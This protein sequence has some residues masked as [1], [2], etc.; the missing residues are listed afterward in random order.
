MESAEHGLPTA[1]EVPRFD[2]GMANIQELIRIMAEA[3]VNEI[4]DARAEDACADGNRRNGIASARSP[5]A[6]A[7]SICASPSSDAKAASQRTFSCAARAWTA[8]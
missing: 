8:R 1:T 2:D 3:L 7:S 6:S 5:P 4:V